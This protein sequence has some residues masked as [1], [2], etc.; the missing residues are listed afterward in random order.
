MGEAME[1]VVEDAALRCELN[2]S[3]K[4]VADS[5]RNRME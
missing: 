2:A 3:F 4:K 5:M 1:D